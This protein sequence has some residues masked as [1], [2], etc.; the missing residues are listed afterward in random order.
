MAKE[1]KKTEAATPAGMIPA[2]Q[3]ARLIMVT[4]Q[5][6]RQLSAKGYIPKAVKG[7]YPMIAVVQGYIKFLKDEERRT[8]KVQADSGLKA[9][10]QREIERRIAREEGK[11][12]EMDDFEA[13]FAFV[14]TKLRAEVLGVPASVSRDL[15]LRGKLEEG[16][17]G[18]FSRARSA[19]GD[20]TEALKSG[21]DPLGT[22]G[23]AD[24]GSMGS[25]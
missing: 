3:A 16:L 14:M 17:N 11:L 9:A 18:A 8:S 19:F 24:A 22:N 21:R 12:G 1:E 15:D 23:K 20:A 2:A 5:W 4:T 10:R 13:V 7:N 6:L 25:S